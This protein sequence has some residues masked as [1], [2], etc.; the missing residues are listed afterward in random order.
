VLNGKRVDYF[1]GE[2]V[3]RVDGVVKQCWTWIGQGD[4]ILYSICQ[5]HQGR[6]VSE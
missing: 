5:I 6:R 3:L 2:S 4:D 1:K